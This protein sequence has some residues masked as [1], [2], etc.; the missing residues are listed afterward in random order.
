[1]HSCKRGPGWARSIH[2][3][4]NVEQS[5]ELREEDGHHLHNGNA[6]PRHRS[7]V[8]AN[9]TSHPRST[10][11]IRSR[12]SASTPHQFDYRLGGIKEREQLS[13]RFETQRAVSRTGRTT[14]ECVSS[15]C[16]P[17]RGC[18]CCRPS[19]PAPPRPL[20]LA[21]QKHPAQ[22]LSQSLRAFP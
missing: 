13:E 20:A 8:G 1:M 10:A 19:P 12:S 22:Q 3:L 9:T 6:I 11:R 2:S 17:G 4:H 15:C 14:C 16:A 21:P 5:P 7:T 18:D